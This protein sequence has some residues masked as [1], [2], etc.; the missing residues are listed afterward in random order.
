MGL[1]Q[2][3][4]DT[5]NFSRLRGRGRFANEILCLAPH[6]K[7]VG[8]TVVSLN[9]EQLQSRAFSSATF[10][11]RSPVLW[12]SIHSAGHGCKTG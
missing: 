7:P 8:E 10:R 3:S 5:G 11:S 9:S 6:P 2:Y 1:L 12:I 4:E